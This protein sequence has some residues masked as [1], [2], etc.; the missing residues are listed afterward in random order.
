MH[1]LWAVKSILHLRFI[2][3]HCKFVAYD[4][5]Y[6]SLKFFRYYLIRNSSTAKV[7]TYLVN[8]LKH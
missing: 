4:C 7:E 3:V 2:P 5:S 6:D 1:F 8:G